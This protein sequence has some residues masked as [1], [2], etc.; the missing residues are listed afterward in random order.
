VTPAGKFGINGFERETHR[1][2]QIAI[3]GYVISKARKRMNEADIQCVA[4][5]SQIVPVSTNE[6]IVAVFPP[7][8]RRTNRGI[9]KK[10]GV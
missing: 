7:S 4:D 2:P 3:S 10:L 6:R 9:S 5:V 1:Y 8:I